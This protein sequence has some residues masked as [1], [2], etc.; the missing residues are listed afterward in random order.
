MAKPQASFFLVFAFA[1]FSITLTAVFVALVVSA[2]PRGE[3]SA[4]TRKWA[5][6]TASGAA[7][8]LASTWWVAAI[9]VIADFD[10]RPPPLMLL[11]LAVAVV[12]SAIALSPLGSRLALG[13]PLATLVAFQSFRFPLELLMHR[14]ATEGVMPEQ[15]SYSGRNFD[16]LTGISAIVVAIALARGATPRLAYAWNIAGALLL[17]N[18]LIVA[19]VS[20][21]IFAAFGQDRLNTWVAYPPFVWLPTVMVVCAISGHLLVWKALRWAG[22]SGGSGR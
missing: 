3:R 5:L 8:W 17:A 19:V 22:R 6:L 13:L 4:T 20:T 15:M 16:I 12:S 2:K 14:A 9:G 1:V 7:A 11:L 21:P 10:R 18:I